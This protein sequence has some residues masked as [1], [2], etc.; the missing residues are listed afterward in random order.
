MSSFLY[1][2][3]QGQPDMWGAAFIEGSTA[4]LAVLNMVLE[5]G[6]W[7]AACEQHLLPLLISEEMRGR[8]KARQETCGIG[9]SVDQMSVCLAFK[10][11]TQDRFS[12]ASLRK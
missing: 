9:R 6:A 12:R 4:E 7:R 1:S 2:L 10:L 5:K 11:E 8:P 3:R